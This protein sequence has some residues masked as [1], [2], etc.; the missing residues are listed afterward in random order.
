MPWN[1]EIM[2]LIDD[3]AGLEIVGMAQG[4]TI[5]GQ[6]LSSDLAEIEQFVDK[7]GFPQQQLVVRPQSEN[8]PRYVK[9]IYTW[10]DLRH[11][12]TQMK[13]VAE[14]RKVFVE[15]DFRAFASP[16]RMQHIESHA[17]PVTTHAQQLPQ[18]R[19]TGYSVVQRQAGLP[20]E[21][22]GTPSLDLYASEI[23]NA[24]AAIISK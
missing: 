22:C 20:C 12:V 5:A 24:F 1:R 6:I 2:V 3:V 9:G 13:L 16:T 18:L 4:S 17:R 7:L 23:L 14:N 10:E 15:P 8:D 19:R 11:H 21:V